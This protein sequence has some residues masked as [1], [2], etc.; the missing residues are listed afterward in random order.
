MQVFKGTNTVP[1]R[2][3]TR[4]AY[5]V[6]SNEDKLR[7]AERLRHLKI[8]RTNRVGLAKKKMLLTFIALPFSDRP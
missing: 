2:F 5:P 6:Q 4:D 3:E 1:E 8:G 7:I